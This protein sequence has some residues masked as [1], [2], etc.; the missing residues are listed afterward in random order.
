M[1]R[2]RFK[3]GQRVRHS[4]TQSDG[5]VVAVDRQYVWVRFDGFSNTHFAISPENL[6]TAPNKAA[7]L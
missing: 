7:L 5:E 4:A 1:K 2:P 6:R 3:L